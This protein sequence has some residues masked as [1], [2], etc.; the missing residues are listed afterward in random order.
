MA[1]GDLMEKERPMPEALNKLAGLLQDWFA[2]DGNSP[3]KLE[4]LLVEF[5][6]GLGKIDRRKLGALSRGEDAALSFAQMKALEAFLTKEYR[7]TFASLFEP[8]ALMPSLL[9]N[10][11]VKVFLGSQPRHSSSEPPLRRTD[12]SRWDVDAMRV[13]WQSINKVSGTVKLDFEDVLCTDSANAAPSTWSSE[14]IGRGTKKSMVS[15]G[16]Q[17]ANPATELMLASMFGVVNAQDPASSMLPFHFVWDQPSKR[18]SA[19]SKEVSKIPQSLMK[20]ARV[21][22]REKAPWALEVNGEY[23][24]LERF[25][26]KSKAYGVL[27]AQRRSFGNSGSQ[28]WLVLAG[29]SGPGTAATARF[30]EDDELSLPR[31]ESGNHSSVLWMAVEADVELIETPGDNRIIGE[32]R[33]L[34]DPQIWEPPPAQ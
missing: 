8:S 32:P 3:N 15:I 19:F 5:G 29:L 22:K 25:V 2:R 31:I 23:Y 21:K 16:S 26:Q 12:I 7:Q 9:L 14:L 33:K 20:Q 17:R 4:A 34:C 6:G 18:P 11:H 30:I 24:L 28:V 13:V 10:N 27:A 1:G